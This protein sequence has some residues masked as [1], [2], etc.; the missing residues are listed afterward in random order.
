M[1]TKKTF[2]ILFLVVF[3]VMVG[4][5]III[6]VLPFLAE[7]L[8]AS[9][10]EL[11]W[12]LAI[13]SIMQ[14]FFSPIWG[15][16]SDRI[17][18]K[19]VMFIGIIGLALSFFIMAWADSLWLLF[20][21]RTLGGILSSANIPTAMAYAADITSAKDRGKGMGIVGAATGMGFVFGPALG[22]I[23]S[24][25]DL[26]FPFYLAALFSLFTAVLVLFVLKESLNQSKNEIDPV[27]KRSVVEQ[28]TSPLIWMFILQ[29]IVSLSMAGLE[30]MYAYYVHD[31]LGLFTVELGY[32][33]MV[34]G[35]ASA[36]VQGVLV[37]KLSKRFGEGKVI[38]LGIFISDIG[39][40][41]ILFS[42]NFFTAALYLTIFGIGNSFIRPAMG[43]FLTKTTT[44]DFGSITGLNS[45]FDSFGRIIGPP[46][47]GWLYE[48]AIGLP[49]IVGAV[50]TFMSLALY[51]IF[52]LHMKK[53]NHVWISGE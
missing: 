12:L 31:K 39:F 34:M 24:K 44:K 22:G 26:S 32:I 50:L 28:L 51:P 37:G 3:L 21:A 43:A 14:L 30:A 17:G 18:R 15:K 10:S 46:L 25:V 48:Y 5:G 52:M 27:P 23:F 47:G 9:P 11:G 45:S 40:V 7:N 19:P 6:P 1:N 38:Q 42:V 49:F 35:V 13:Y 4:F 2:L 20:V 36:V 29:L 33:F 41:L 53:R 8:G 16:I